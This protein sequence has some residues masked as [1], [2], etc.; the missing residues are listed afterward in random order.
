MGKM[1]YHRIKLTRG[2]YAIVDA[3][4]FEWLSFYKWH[5]TNTGYAATRDRALRRG[6]LHIH[7]FI[8]PTNYRQEIDHI[9]H[10]KLDNRKANLRICSSSQNKYN[11]SVHR[12]SANGFKGVEK[13]NSFSNPWIARISVGKGRVYLGCF[14]TKREAA[15]AYKIAAKKY[16]GEFARW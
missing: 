2:K 5:Y 1:K 16:H 14:A 12:D 3:E 13:C 6:I 8:C 9:N 15:K 10:N 11:R 4:D 7:R